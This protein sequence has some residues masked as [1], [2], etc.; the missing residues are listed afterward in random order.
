MV[1]RDDVTPTETFSYNTPNIP[2]AT[3]V[4][5]ALAFKEDAYSLVVDTGLCRLTRA[6]ASP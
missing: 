3:V 5:V 2:G 6:S 4:L 1:I